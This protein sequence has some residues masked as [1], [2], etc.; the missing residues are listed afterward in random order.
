MMRHAPGL[1]ASPPVRYILG[2]ARRGCS[3][4]AGPLWT[5][6]PLRSGGPPRTGGTVGP[7]RSPV[8]L[9]MQPPNE[10]FFT[11]FSE[12]G[13]NIVERVAIPLAARSGSVIAAVAVRRPD[14]DR[15][16]ARM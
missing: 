4:P 8:G 6:E 1:P 9:R 16:S 10:E 5:D 7:G 13:S 12:A 14:A 11:L 2:V 15:R 3:P